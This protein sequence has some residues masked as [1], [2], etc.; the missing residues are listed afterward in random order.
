[1]AGDENIALPADYISMVTLVVNDRQLKYR[2]SSFLSA[3]FPDLTQG[4]PR[5]FSDDHEAGVYQVRLRPIPNAVYTGSMRYLATPVSLTA[6]A[7]SGTTWISTNMEAAL[8]YGTLMHAALYIMDK[9][10]AETYERKFKEAVGL[11]K[12]EQEGKALDD[13]RR[14]DYARPKWQE[15]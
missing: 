4:Q 9:P 15:E 12:I 11:T 8:V 7:G 3:A 6:G 13:R 1:V 14:K 2:D 10:L 5:F